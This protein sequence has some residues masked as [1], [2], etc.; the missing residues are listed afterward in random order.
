MA[1]HTYPARVL[2]VSALFSLLVLGLC[3]TVAYWLY[4]E[5]SRAAE[6][7]GENIGSRGAAVNLESTLTN[8]ITLHK[9]R[10]KH[11]SGLHEE[12]KRYLD[13]INA[14][15]DK[16]QERV[17]AAQ[18]DA[19][20]R[21]Y[22][23]Q[24][25]RTDLEGPDALNLATHL[26]DHALAHCRELRRFNSQEVEASEQEHREALRRMTWGL[27]TVGGVGSVAGI[28][29]G[30]AL[31]RSMQ[32]TIHQFLLRVQGASDLLGQEVPAVEWQR[33]GDPLGDGADDLIRRVE[34]VIS[35]LQRQ[36]R[37]V[38]RNERLAAVGQLAAGVAHE[39]RNPLTS[40]IL[41]L[42]TSRKDP[43]CGGLTDDDLELVEQELHRIERSLQ[44]FLDFARPPRIERAD[45]DAITIARDTLA[46][47]RG[48]AESQHVT[49]A[50]KSVSDRC[51][52]LADAEQL[53]HVL[54]NLVL[55]SF[56]AMPHGGALD[57]AVSTQDGCVV[58]TVSDTGTGISPELLPRLF[59]PFVTGKET[60]IGLGLMMSKRIVEDHGG[61]ITG[62]NRPE[63][64]AKF[65]VQI[66][67]DR[68]EASAA[69]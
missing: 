40:A 28:I 1:L 54:L 62:Q 69:G 30:F 12:V 48:R 59:E 34:Q 42:E 57:L 9:A 20:F 64:G 19:D 46:L 33:E 16:E 65:L 41:L 23:D 52:L 31:A 11:L 13:D 17:F 63:G 45:C 55:N 37:D 29:F 3:G 27:A 21:E 26:Q 5:Q 50:L 24:L 2:S 7:L 44:T 43:T 47:V 4:R 60:G 66:P 15:A 14:Y 18:I 49:V 61:I 51:W 36:E 67:V 32:R 53:K 56:D 35:K 38:R 8:L 22:L 68:V 10:A 25:R 39:V 6:V 58:F